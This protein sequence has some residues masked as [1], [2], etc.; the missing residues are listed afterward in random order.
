MRF[1]GAGIGL[2]D[3]AMMCWYVKEV[4]FMSRSGAKVRMGRKIK[5]SKVEMPEQQGLK[6]KYWKS[7]KSAATTKALRQVENTLS[8][9]KSPVRWCEMKL[10]TKETSES[11]RTSAIKNTSNAVHQVGKCRGVC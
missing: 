8:L 2:G 5:Y 7:V 3:V 4:G 9:C 10:T 1:L 6:V 11:Q